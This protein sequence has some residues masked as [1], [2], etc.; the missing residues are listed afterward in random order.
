MRGHDRNANRVEQRREHPRHRH[1]HRVI[2]QGLDLQRLA[3][4]GEAGLFD[5]GHARVIDHAHRKGDV[6]R[7]EWLS[8]EPF[9]PVAQM[10]NDRLAAIA[11]LPA[12]GETRLGQGRDRIDPDQPFKKIANHLTRGRVGDQDRIEGARV[13]DRRLVENLLALVLVRRLLHAAS[14]RR[15]DGEHGAEKD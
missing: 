11:Q 4:N 3:V 7:R 15:G 1:P 10:E 2:I 13:A 9:H 8:V 14:D 6:A 12:L 5:I